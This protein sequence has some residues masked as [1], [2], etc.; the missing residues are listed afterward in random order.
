MGRTIKAMYPITLYNNGKDDRERNVVNINQERLN[1]NFRNIASEL[2]ALW[3]SGDHTLNYLSARVSAD[4]E[5]FITAPDAEGIATTAIQ[6]SAV[7]LAMP[8]NILQQ[9]SQLIEGYVASDDKDPEH[10]TTELQRAV[11]SLVKQRA[12]EIDIIFTQVDTALG[13]TSAVVQ[14]LSSWIKVVPDNTVAGTNA[15]VI[16]GRSTSASNFKAEA[17]HIY[18]Y[19]GDDDRGKWANALAGLD[20][21]G[22]FIAKRAHLDSVLLSGAFDVDLVEAHGIDFLHITGRM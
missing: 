19:S 5:R 18:F 1:E 12:D 21:D 2:I 14:D 13:E 20:A 11:A 4:E 10:Q 16:I 9:V 22:N 3:E 8:D 6:N 15:G 7:I 17:D